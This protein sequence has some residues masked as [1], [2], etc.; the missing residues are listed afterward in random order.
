MNVC[1]GM[2]CLKGDEDVL[3]VWVSW[4]EIVVQVDGDL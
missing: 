1:F 3:L 4:G 2:F